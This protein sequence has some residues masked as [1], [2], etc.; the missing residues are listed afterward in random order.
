MRKKREGTINS[1][2]IETHLVLT[3]VGYLCAEEDR[4]IAEGMRSSS[5]QKT[6]FY[7]YEEKF[8]KCDQTVVIWC[9]QDFLFTKK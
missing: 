3:L 7:H 2:K 6:S 9:L 1:R 4:Y 5:R 8:M